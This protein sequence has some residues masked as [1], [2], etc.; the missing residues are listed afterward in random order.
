MIH[1]LRYTE[2]LEKAGFSAEQ[3]KASVKIWMDLMSDNFAT[4]SD[5]KE[6]QFITRN[7]LRDHQQ[8]FSR[9]LSQVSSRFDELS[10]VQVELNSEMK[11]LESRLTVKL[12]SIMVIGIG[13]LGALKLI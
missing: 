2:D 10:R 12:G 1:A 8:I 3:A 7:D 4:K 5:L 11:L 9:E 13:L 6:H